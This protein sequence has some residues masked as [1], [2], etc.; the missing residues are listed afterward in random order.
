MQSIEEELVNEQTKLK[1]HTR[2]QPRETMKWKTWKGSEDRKCRNHEKFQLSLKRFL[3]EFPGSSVI[4]TQCFHCPGPG[5]NL[6][7]G[8]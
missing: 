4:R 1:Q 3:Q 7:W 8:Y 2:I 5:F 6:W